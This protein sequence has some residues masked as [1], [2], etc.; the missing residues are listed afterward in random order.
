MKTLKTLAITL[1]VLTAV[2]LTLAASPALSGQRYAINE[3]IVMSP[4][5]SQQ[6]EFVINDVCK[7]MKLEPYNIKTHAG[8]LRYLIIRHATNTNEIMINIVT[9]KK[10]TNVIET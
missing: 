9:S 2:F 10:N 3:V 6:R 5:D 4:G 7:Q 1:F 8:F